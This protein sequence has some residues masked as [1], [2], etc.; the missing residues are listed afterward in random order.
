MLYP[1]FE[2]RHFGP[3]SGTQAHVRY[4]LAEKD[5]FIVVDNVLMLAGGWT[6][7][8]AP[9]EG[10]RHHWTRREPQAAV[11]KS[12]ERSLVEHADIWT[13]LAKH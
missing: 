7:V 6:L 10:R 9:S 5:R 8:S 1:W 3:S 4:H 2:V 12:L 13:E 11:V